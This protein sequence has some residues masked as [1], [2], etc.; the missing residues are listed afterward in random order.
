MIP[1]DCQLPLHSLIACRFPHYRGLPIAYDSLRIPAFPL[2]FPAIACDCRFPRIADCLRF[3][4][5]SDSL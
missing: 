2:R 4:I 3:P 5:A 1:Y